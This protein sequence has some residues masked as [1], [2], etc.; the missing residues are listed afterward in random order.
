V[1]CVHKKHIF[2]TVMYVYLW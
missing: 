1:T 2:M